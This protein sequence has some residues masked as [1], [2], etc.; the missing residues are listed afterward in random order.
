MDE[1]PRHHDQIRGQ[2]KQYGGVR[3]HVDVSLHL[4]ARWRRLQ[5][6]IVSCG[7]VVGL[8]LRGDKVA[9]D[10]RGQCELLKT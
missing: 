1:V 6:E 5:Q 10:T 2:P 9:G 3:L 7:A 4:D 8:A